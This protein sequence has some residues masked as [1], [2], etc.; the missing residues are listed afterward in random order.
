M[1]ENWYKNNNTYSHNL[2]TVIYVI[3]NI[4]FIQVFSQKDC[5]H[6]FSGSGKGSFIVVITS[7]NKILI[8]KLFLQNENINKTK[9]VRN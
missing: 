2:N 6:N 5:G 7:L 4:Y 1:I 3:Q 9:G 8:Y